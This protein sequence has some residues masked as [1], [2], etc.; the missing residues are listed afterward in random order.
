MPGPMLVRAAVSAARE[1]TKRAAESLV[2]GLVAGALHL[3]WLSGRFTTE[4]GSGG[5][6]FLFGCTFITGILWAMLAL[7]SLAA[8]KPI[9]PEIDDGLVSMAVTAWAIALIPPRAANFIPEPPIDDFAKVYLPVS[10]VAVFLVLGAQVLW[11]M[12][13]VRFLWLRL[14]SSL[15]VSCF[16]L[17]GF[18]FFV[19]GG[20]GFGEVVTRGVGLGAVCS[21]VT[22]FL[23]WRGRR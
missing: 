6:T 15:A 13:E 19:S 17:A 10:L 21:L 11:P 3:T 18:V 14:F 16:V 9:G 2:V 4:Q 8:D 12:R 1:E 20:A 7:R 5:L 22:G 23:W